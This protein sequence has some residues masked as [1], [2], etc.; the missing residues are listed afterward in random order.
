MPDAILLGAACAAAFLS[1]P[2]TVAVGRRVQ[3]RQ[4]NTFVY[5][6]DLKICVTARQHHLHST[7]VGK[8]QV[9]RNHH[10]TRSRSCD[11]RWGK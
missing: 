8:V 1:L 2:V 7:L 5:N 6:P 9:H 4:E 3:R 10:T 11:I